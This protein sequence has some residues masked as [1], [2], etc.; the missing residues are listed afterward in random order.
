MPLALVPDATPRFRRRWLA[1]ALTT[2]ACWGI[3]GALIELPEKAG[4]PATLG[5][6]IWSLTML[7][8]A[9]VALQLVGWRFKHGQRE[10]VLASMAG[11]L[12]AGGQLI[13]FQALKDGPAFIVFPLISLYPV[14]TILCSVFLLHEKI[15]RRQWVGIAVALPAIPLLSYIEPGNTLVRGSLWLVLSVG[16]LSMWGI[17][18][19]LIKLLNT[20]MRSEEIFFYMALTGMALIPIAYGMTDFTQPIEW[21]WRGPG[22]AALIHML[23]SVGALTLVYALR[24]GQ[25]MIVVPMTSLAPVITIVFS[26][27]IYQRLPLIPQAV[28]MILAVVGILLMAE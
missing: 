18:G 26:L 4:F 12:G 17:Q 16:V 28:G 21:G 20:R 3:W 27:A 2:T 6:M 14:L 25:A 9:L 23:N 1:F 15:R 5:Y 8:C 24:E 10:F 7:P 22:S 11:L 13:L 19:Y